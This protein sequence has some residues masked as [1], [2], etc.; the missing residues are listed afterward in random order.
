MNR[1]INKNIDNLVHFRSLI[2]AL[3]PF[4][5]NLDGN[6]CDEF[7]RYIFDIINCAQKQ[8]DEISIVPDDEVRDVE[9]FK[10]KIDKLKPFIPLEESN[11]S[12]KKI[13]F[14]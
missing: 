7:Y 12:Q 14:E 10:Q 11:L 6:F 3:V 5:L 13:F 8:V 4:D 9:M 2:I 1:V